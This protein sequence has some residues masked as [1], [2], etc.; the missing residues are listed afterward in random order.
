MSTV[1]RLTLNIELLDIS[2]ELGE[3][4]LVHELL[5]LLVP[6]YGS[7]LKNFMYVYKSYWEG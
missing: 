4:V 2:K 3:F 5:E 6:N 1:G 7:V